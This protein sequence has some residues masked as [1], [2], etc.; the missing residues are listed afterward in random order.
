MASLYIHMAFSKLL[1]EELNL[2]EEQLMAGTLVADTCHF[3]EDKYK[4][5]SHFGSRIKKANTIMFANKYKE[6]IKDPFILGYLAHLYIDE[7]FY[8]EVIG[9]NYKLISG[10]SYVDPNSMFIDKRTNEVKNYKEVYMVDNLYRDYALTSYPIYKKYNLKNDICL[11]NINKVVE[12]ID[13]NKIGEINKELE[14]YKPVP[15]EGETNCIDLNSINEFLIKHKRDFLKK[16]NDFI[17][18]QNNKLKKKS[19]LVKEQIG[20]H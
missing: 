8:D 19:I 15:I 20:K 13:Y 16:Y 5:K 2:D 7:C 11:D 3:D 12:E 17:S 9:E 4:E 6:H 18:V 1:N 10:K 14:K